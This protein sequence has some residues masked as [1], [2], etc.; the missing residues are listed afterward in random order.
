[1]K[2]SQGGRMWWGVVSADQNGSAWLAVRTRHPT[3]RQ[4]AKRNVTFDQ[5]PCPMPP[6]NVCASET[7]AGS[8]RTL[9]LLLA[10]LVLA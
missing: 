10:F 6:R 5:N 1:M 3:R 2:D 7:P 8:P 4:S 9:R